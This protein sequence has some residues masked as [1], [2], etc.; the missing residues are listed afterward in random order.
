MKL[1]FVVIISLILIVAFGLWIYRVKPWIHEYTIET[2]SDSFSI[3]SYKANAV[4]KINGDFYISLDITPAAYPPESF[5]IYR[6]AKNGKI[7]H[8]T[9]VDTSPK[10]RFSIIGFKDDYMLVKFRTKNE[11]IEFMNK[12]HYPFEYY[13]QYL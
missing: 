8:I 5:D 1:K 7:V 4:S 9:L 12:F 6:Y 2:T 3:H 10:Y 13:S 11:V